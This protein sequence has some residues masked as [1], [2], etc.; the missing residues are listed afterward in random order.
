MHM[1]LGQLHVCT[2]IVFDMFVGNAEAT[3]VKMAWSGWEPCIL[4]S[5]HAIS[6]HTKNNVERNS[7]LQ[8][9]EHWTINE[10]FYDCCLSYI[11]TL[12]KYENNVIF[13]SLQHL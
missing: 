4:K 9:D 11:S 3:S 12:Y 2:I 13:K 10:S 5:C 8:M 6:K 1:V 7:E